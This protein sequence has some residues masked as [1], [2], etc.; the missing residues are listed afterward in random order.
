MSPGRLVKKTIGRFLLSLLVI[1]SP[2][3]GLLAKL[4]VQETRGWWSRRQAAHAAAKLIDGGSQADAAASATS[5]LA[6]LRASPDDPA[7]M[8]AWAQWLGRNKGSIGDRVSA[9]RQIANSSAATARDLAELAGALIED[10]KIAEA[11]TVIGK[12][13]EPELNTP[14]MLEVR[15]ALL[16]A[17]GD[18]KAGDELRQKAW[19]SDPGN[20]ESRLKLALL[21]LGEFYEENR[22]QALTALWTLVREK[23]DAALKAAEVLC[24]HESLGRK[25]SEELL[26]LV[27]NHPKTDKRIRYAALSGVLRTHP[28]TRDKIIKEELA[29]AASYG[30]EDLINLGLML[31]HVRAYSELLAIIPPQ[32]ALLQREL[33]I[34]RVKA[35]S[36]CGS[37]SE[38]EAMLADHSHLPLSRGHKAVLAAHLAHQKGERVQAMHTLALSLKQAISDLDAETVLRAAMMAEEQGWWDIASECH[39][40]LASSGRT[41]V[42]ESLQSLFRAAANKRDAS[43]MLGTTERMVEARD[44]SLQTLTTLAYLRLLLG[45]RLETV[46]TIL[47]RIL[48]RRSGGKA[49]ADTYGSFLRAFLCYRYGDKDGLRENIS[50]IT[51]WSAIPP[52]QRAVSAVLLSLSG[53]ESLAHDLAWSVRTPALLAEEHEFWTAAQRQAVAGLNQAGNSPG[54]EPTKGQ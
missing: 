43:L 37:Y 34:L 22:K 47:D 32:K 12:L 44:D 23:N 4:G 19:R 51:D 28:E 29:K 25:Q 33:C 40:W 21:Q 26:A 54:N 45:S 15:A 30:P 14:L 46:S 5:I 48:Q 41:D 17:E 18:R 11:K 1:A 36:Q 49:T 3:L 20:P 50:G 35:L 13:P 27:E 42:L 2:L 9:W 6:A 10:R 39:D 24:T 52:G 16:D 7:I 38:L 31:D 8:R 53:R